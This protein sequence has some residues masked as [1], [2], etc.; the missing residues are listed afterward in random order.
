MADLQIHQ[1]PAGVAIT[2]DDFLPASQ[3]DVTNKITTLDVGLFVANNETVVTALS[4]NETFVTELTN[5]TTFLT[6][7]T[8]NETFIDNIVVEIVAEDVW[9]DTTGDT[10]TGTLYM[11]HPSAVDGADIQPLGDGS[12]NISQVDLDTNIYLGVS[13][14]D[15]VEGGTGSIIAG[16]FRSAIP[17]VEAEP[18][19]TVLTSNRHASALI[20]YDSATPGTYTVRKNDNSA[21]SDFFLGNYFSVTQYGTGSITLVPEDENVILLIPAGFIASPRDQYSVITAT[22][23]LADVD[24]PG[25]EIV[26]AQH[27]EETW[28]ISGDMA[29]AP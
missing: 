23:I 3:A 16:R 28:L 22:L 1:L 19:A 18:D 6:E 17:I 20:T 9:V 2:E 14:A 24:P 29:E 12:L 10:M 13:T 4:H 26:E 11:K 27:N 21:G 7:L 8:S 5:D 15:Q 25:G